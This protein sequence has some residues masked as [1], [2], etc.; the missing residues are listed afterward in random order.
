MESN[1]I[2][3][4]PTQL[5][6]TV[7]VN[8]EPVNEL[9]ILC[10]IDPHLSSAR[11]SSRKDDYGKTMIDKLKRIQ[12]VCEPMAIDLVV[13]AGDIFHRK[14]EPI[15]YLVA[16]MSAFKDF[17]VPIYVVVGNHDLFYGRLDTLSKSPLAILIGSGVMKHLGVINVIVA[18]KSV[19]ILGK[20][21]EPRL[22][23]PKKPAN[24]NIGILVA[25][26]FLKS[27]F[28]QEG[29]ADD[30]IGTEAVSQS[31]WDCVL[32]GHDHVG[33][34]TDKRYGGSVIRP[35]AL[36]RGTKHVYN[37]ARQVGFAVIDIDKDGIRD[38]F[39]GLPVLP[40]SEV[41]SENIEKEKNVERQLTEFVK[42]LRERHVEET[43][44]SV[45]LKSIC[46]EP[47]VLGFI[48][49]YFKNFGV[50]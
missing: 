23:I 15:P 38:A 8:L 18:G 50:V 3:E 35:G 24:V 32:L 47:D 22:K 36:S 10:F 31:G 19:Q 34:P 14:R 37:I 33:Y 13:V 2:I 21:F 25:H 16:V 46:S 12:E 17:R 28:S 6:D 20:S 48:E 27:Q 11:P 49:E 39:V 29:G 4:I 1:G 43:K 40:S 45:M 26:A 44:I 42:S 7:S 41:F 9:R 30:E 5:L